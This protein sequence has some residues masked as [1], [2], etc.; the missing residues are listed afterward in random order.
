MDPATG[1]LMLADVATE[2][3]QVMKNLQAIL[4]EAGLGFNNVLKTSIFL[5][6]MGDFAQVNEVYGRCFPGDYAPARE[7]VQVCALPKGVHVEISMIA[8]R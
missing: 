2:T 5:T 4:T 3:E 1:D 6:S 7:T 8:G